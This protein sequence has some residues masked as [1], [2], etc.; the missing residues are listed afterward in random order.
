MERSK[1]FPRII[2]KRLLTPKEAA[3]YL[4]ISV[5]K[6]EYLKAK[7]IVAQTQLPD[8]RKRLY[9]LHDLDEFLDKLK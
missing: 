1:M 4:G 7:G 8:T 5:R 6:L 3:S 2:T 9:D